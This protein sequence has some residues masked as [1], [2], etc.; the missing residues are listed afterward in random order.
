M[1]NNIQENVVEA[2]ENAP[3][4]EKVKK[5]GKK[6]G[7]IIGAVAVVVAV[8]AIAIVMLL[9]GSA[10]KIEIEGKSYSYSAEEGIE[11]IEKI[12]D[13]VVVY[14]GFSG[15]IHTTSGEVQEV[16]GID[17]LG[18]KYPIAYIGTR[19]ISADV[20]VTNYTVYG[21][22]KTSQGATHNSATD[23]LAKKDYMVVGDVY[24]VIKT[25]KG[26]ID[27][28]DIEKD[29]EKVISDNSFKGIDYIDSASLAGGDVAKIA[30]SSD[31]VN[32][33]LDF[34]PE[35]SKKAGMMYLLSRGKAI[36][37]LINGE[38]QYVVEE[39]VYAYE[40]GENMLNISIYTSVENAE[41]IKESMGI[42][43]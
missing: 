4:E 11:D 3:A 14:T 12:C 9:G 31:D 25:D 8:A 38:A 1:D 20:A 19:N 6:T 29:Y 35:D 41:K 39:G 23:E 18:G 32:M 26:I 21:E 7:I 28:S 30:V 10:G 13:G 33:L 34:Y 42:T 2:K 36:D 17:V 43:K 16:S 24:N 22:F 5:S 40:E 37:M 15:E 27:Y